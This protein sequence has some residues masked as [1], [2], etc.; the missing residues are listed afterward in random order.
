[1]APAKSLRPVRIWLLIVAALVGATVLVGGATRLTE[2]G[3]SI[4]EWRPVTG[5][6]PPLS[7]AQWNEEFAK[8]REIPQYQQVN[9]GMSLSEFKYIYYWEWGHRLLGRLIGLA[10]AVPL[11]VF[12]WQGRLT[13]SL[14]PKL[15][16]LLFLGGLQGFIGWWMVTSGLVTRTSVAPY[17]LATHLTLAFFIFA[18]LFYVARSLAPKPLAVPLAVR[19]TGWA[20]LV[21]AFVQ[22]FL[23][24]I[25]AGLD[26]GLSYTTWPLMDGALIPSFAQMTP[27]EPL[28]RNLFENPMASQFAHRMTAY[29]LLALAAF[30]ALQARGTAAARPAV[31]LLITVSVQA[32]IGILTLIH[33]VPISLA[34]LHQLGALGVIAHAVSNVQRFRDGPE[35]VQIGSLQ[36]ARPA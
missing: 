19:A 26:A 3:L 36:S 24:A 1:M 20:V 12:W 21:L 27:L 9:R 29:A 5:T 17:R 13:R 11:A 6:L 22:V 33:L 4:T 25:V 8:Y 7:D 34:L 2:S 10:F 16:L 32:V 28:W 15:L 14:T 23:G 35:P 30:H 18:Y 31:V